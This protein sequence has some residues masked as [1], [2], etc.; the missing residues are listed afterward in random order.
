MSL[1]SIANR[2]E[3]TAAVSRL[4]AW[5]SDAVDGSDSPVLHVTGA[6]GS[7]PAFLLYHIHKT[8]GA[9][10]CCLVPDEDAAAYLQS[11]L[12]QLVTDPE[13]DILRVPATR[14]TPYD[15]EQMSDSTPLIERAD[16]LQRL[17]EGFTGLLV[18]SVDAVGELVPPPEAVQNETL[19]VETGEEISMD[20]LVERLVDQGFSPVEFVDEPGQLAR[21]GG[22]LDVFP[23]AG[24]YP[25]RVDFFGDEIDGLREFDPETQRSV[26]RLTTARLV[27]NLERENAARGSIPLFEYL[28]E[29]VILATVDETQ[30]REGAQAQYDEAVEAYEDR[31]EELSED[32]DAEESPDDLTPPDERFLDGEHFAAAL[33]RHPRLLFGT[34][35]ASTQTN[36]TPKETLD[37]EA[38]PQPSFNSDM[39]VVRDRLQE[40]GDRDLDTF[41]LCDS[42]GQ[43]SRL[44]DL[45]E[46]EIDHGWARLVVESLHEG[47]EL[48]AASLA[49]YTDHQIF[50][51]YHR[52]ST[53][54]RKKYSGGMSLRDIKNLTPGDFVV[55][56]D[57]GIG[58]FAGLK[59]ITVRDK[60]QEAVRLNFADNDI[61]YVNV[62]ALHKLNKYTGKEGHS[63][64]L[65]KL[66]SGQ[67]EKTKERTKSKVKDIARDLIK[68]YAKR[69]ASDGY[70]FSSD[71]TWQREMEASFE[72][73]DTPDQA[74]AAEAVKRDME[75]PVP[76][77][78]LVCGDVGFGKTEVAV[79]AAFK[80]VQDGKQVA[81][82]VPTTIL[83]QQHH[84]TFSR[85]LER[86][87]V[88]VEVLSRFR[89][90]AE[91][92]EVLKKLEKGQVDV[93]IGTHR[94]TSDD[95]EFD[96]LGLLIID[97]EQRFGVKTKEKLRKMRASID[98]LTL[99]ATPIPRTLQF[100]LL[101][102]RDLSLI[103]TPPP[104][105]Q[106]INTEIHTFDQDLI[107]DAIVYETSRGGQVF[108]IHNR[109]KTINEVAEMV[110]AM[111]PDV[112][113]GVGHGQMSASELEDV[114][115]DF[116][117]EKLDVLV[118]TSIIENGVDISNAN[119]MIINHAGSHF[120]LSELH[121]LR[122]RVGRSQRKAFCYLLVPSI[123]S[124]TD[125]A[126][127]RL[128]AVEQFS[129][130]GSGFDIAMRD[131]DIRGAGSLL[132]A[133]QSGF[134]EDVGYEMYHKILDQAMKELR[135]E[136]FEEVFDGEAVPPGPE[137]SVDVEED[138]YIPDEYVRDNTERL[139]LYRRISDAPDETTLVDLLDELED[140]FGDV[141]DPVENLL[142]GA[143]LRLLGE[144]LRM[145]K[146]VYKNERLFLYLP[147]ENA[148]PY[149]YEEVFHPLLEKLSLLD[150]EYVMKDDVEG[151]L[152]RAIVQDVSTLNDALHVMEDLLLEETATVATVEA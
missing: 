109:V 111:V 106:P 102:A 45:L 139:N 110:R 18:T 49:V 89:T 12:E 114:M 92:T 56:V 95:I 119:T 130:L 116:L 134:V 144:R 124:L 118:S 44:R 123:H 62:N 146:V 104:N 71:T 15:P 82:L 81:M 43:S 78:R 128:K 133:E 57:H 39:D 24:S 96:D 151:G 120:G 108:F 52:P 14:K 145:P 64:T 68:L 6:A 148:D 48:P 36:G 13:E 29:D 137:T 60:Q 122:G 147:S 53:K 138:A 37:L 83:A 99:T 135:E 129:D 42:H 40:N 66:G 69:K 77:D 1:S 98:T 67:W 100:S 17:A 63:P 79:R 125:D 33:D 74:E 112:R 28:P 55:H 32:E 141:P 105:R 86:F 23:Y 46:S 76:M 88:N 131:L 127:E 150:R 87:P 50:N 35:A 72:F 85:R 126:R 113:V 21:R 93:I 25:V 59:Q 8:P 11:D 143:Q 58:K 61:L 115:V 47:F 19:T 51:R 94:I 27:P 3:T 142:T 34:F 149:F 117:T 54:K 65:T 136:E 70:A 103:K 107:R 121:Q 75:E 22:I 41:I 101:G 16:A 20:A 5:A 73:E 91:Q 26:S 140:R 132:G 90:Q 4:R 38:D 152:M 7:L 97:E 2:I 30:L 80:A 31:K 84:E 10:L 9:P